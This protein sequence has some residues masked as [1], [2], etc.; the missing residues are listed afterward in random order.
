MG[1]TLMSMRHRLVFTSLFFGLALISMIV[2]L[3]LIDPSGDI[4]H[5]F[6]TKPEPSTI[7]T[8]PSEEAMAS[9]PHAQTQAL[10][11]REV[12]IKATLS[13]SNEAQFFVPKTAMA[14]VYVCGKGPKFQAVSVLNADVLAPDN[15]TWHE[16]ENGF[17]LQA[18]AATQEQEENDA[19]DKEIDDYHCKGP[20]SFTQLDA[21]HYRINLPQG[22]EHALV[23]TSQ[24]GPERLPLMAISSALV[25]FMLSFSLGFRLP[26]WRLLDHLNLRWSL[27]AL[28]LFGL[29]ILALAPLMAAILKGFPPS[30][31][32]SFEAGTLIYLVNFYVTI[33]AAL[34]ILGLVWLKSRSPKTT[35]QASDTSEKTLKT[36]ATLDQ[37]TAQKPLPTPTF[38]PILGMALSL[39]ALAFTTLILIPTNVTNLTQSVHAFSSYLI[40]I[41]GFAMFAAIA[42]ELLYRGVIQSGIENSLKHR[43]LA[44]APVAI[45][46]I[47]IPSIVFV[48][49]HIPQTLQQP[50]ALLPIATLSLLA[51][52]LKWRYQRI[53]PSIALHMLYNAT[54]LLTSFLAFP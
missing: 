47:L 28:L 37:E 46:S 1:Q 24:R 53:L 17:L 3:C 18:P 52:I 12:D 4:Y 21:G 50:F 15:A 22:V 8:A 51:G 43:G 16:L 30:T 23:L 27:A 49:M 11:G 32:Q 20:A 54:I 35:P 45:L 40:L 10:D 2:G 9:L 41:M 39:V 26:K 14:Q 6:L 5:E 7:S 19:Q 44:K 33:G 42:E 36:D 25:F 48:A 38:F 29:G 31:V 34:L 13:L